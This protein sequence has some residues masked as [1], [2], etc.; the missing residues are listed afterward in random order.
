MPQ[1]SS[2]RQTNTKKNVK[3]SVSDDVLTTNGNSDVTEIK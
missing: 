2:T 1:H 3:K